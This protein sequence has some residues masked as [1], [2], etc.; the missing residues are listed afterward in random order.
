MRKS[1]FNYIKDILSDYYQTDAY[2]KQREEELRHPFIEADLNSSIRGQG[3]HSVATER[4]AITIAMDRRL[5]NLERNRDVV[6][7]CLARADENT[8]EIIEKLYLQKN[9]TVNLLGM[10][11]RLFISKSKAYELRNDFFEAVADELG[12]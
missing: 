5:W 1:T 8:K 6:K 2:I 9:A 12:L 10:S 4:M 11:Q 7:D 3:N